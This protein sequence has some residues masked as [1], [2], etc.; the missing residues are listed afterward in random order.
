MKTI[1]VPIDFSN[2]T[3]DV[4]EQAAQLAAAFS[5]AVWLLHVAAPEPEFVG[6]DSGPRDVRE[7][8]AHELH[9]SHR[10]LQEH[11]TKLRARGINATAIQVQGA[12]VETILREAERLHADVIV[13]GSHGHGA[14]H[15]ALLGSVSEGVLHH[16]T[17]PLLILPAR[18]PGR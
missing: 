14:V 7:S 18:K 10:V 11:S 5:S 12:T 15:R 3:A 8:V 9:E 13:L 17:C 2:A 16:A 1:L 4:V 6:Y